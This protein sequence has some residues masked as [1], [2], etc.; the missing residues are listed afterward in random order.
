MDLKLVFE[1]RK[2]GKYIELAIFDNLFQSNS[3]IFSGYLVF[4]FLFFSGSQFLLLF[5][6]MLLLWSN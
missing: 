1:A 5:S 6:L 2:M 4:F 3:E